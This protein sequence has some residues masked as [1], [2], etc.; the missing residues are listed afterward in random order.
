M[1]RVL[2]LSCC[3]DESAKR[4]LNLCGWN[5]GRVTQRL[6]FQY[7]Y[8]PKLQSGSQLCSHMRRSSAVSYHLKHRVEFKQ[9]PLS[10]LRNIPFFLSEM[11][12]SLL[13]L[14]LAWMPTNS[15][16]PHCTHRSTARSQ[17]NLIKLQHILTH[18]IGD[19]MAVW[20]VRSDGLSANW[21]H[22]LI[23][24]AIMYIVKH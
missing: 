18:L 8:L 20:V 22:S 17:H 3:F 15:L 7:L 24:S 13:A 4:G 2:T 10:K 19:I 6:P 23:P 9:P 14:G 21:E 1:L 5:G 11:M 16:Y 12:N